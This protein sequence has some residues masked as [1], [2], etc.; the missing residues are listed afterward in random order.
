MAVV[1][2]FF[3]QTITEHA[4]MKGAKQVVLMPVTRGEENKEWAKWTPS[5]RLEMTINNEAAAA[6]F[7][8]GEEYLLRFEHAPKE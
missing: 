2:K 7:L 1:A 3:V 4:S 6:E 8:L 5:G